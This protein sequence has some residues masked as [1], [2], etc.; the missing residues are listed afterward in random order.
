MG[1]G[2]CRARAR[3][4][5]LRVTGD[6][7][8]F[9]VVHCHTLAQAAAVVVPRRGS[10]CSSRTEADSYSKLGEGRKSDG[11]INTEKNKEE[12]I[13]SDRNHCVCSVFSRPSTLERKKAGVEI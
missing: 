12:N 8:L 4:A 9:W 3:H 2:V 7:Y 1:A 13:T 5:K 6:L 11:P 10:P